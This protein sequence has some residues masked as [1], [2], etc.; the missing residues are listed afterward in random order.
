M[1]AV[2]RA[3]A[4]EHR[5][6][7][8]GALI[9]VVPELVVDRREVVGR[10]LDA[11]LDAQVALEVDVPRARV[12]DDVAI[13]RADEE[14][15]LPER[16][17]QR[18]ESERRVE[19]LARSHHVERRHV[20]L[21]QD[22]GEREA[23]VG[24]RRRHERIHVGPVLRPDVAEQVR[25]N[26]T[27]RRHDLAVLLAQLQPRVRVELH[28]QRPHLI[29]EPI[30]LA[31]ERVGRHVVLR[32]PH[33]P[34]VGEPELFRSLVRELDE[35]LVVLPHRRR[36]GVPPFPCRPQLA[37]V[38]RRRHDPRHVVDRS[39]RFRLGR[40]GTPLALAVH[41]LEPRHDLRQLVR[42]LRIGRRREH[43]RRL[44][45]G[46]FAAFARRHVDV[47]VLRRLLREACAGIVGRLVGARGERFGV[48]GDVGLLHPAGA[49]RLDPELH[50]RL[51][52]GS[53]KRF[54]VGRGRRRRGRAARARGGGAAG[55]D[56]KNE[57]AHG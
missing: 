17:R 4:E 33:R 16:V 53:E 54:R 19:A 51:V 21:L 12:A 2:V 11:H 34:R 7:L 41:R 29:P 31:G 49:A 36:D 52:D 46:Q 25:R 13:A 57:P 48:V 30:E 38:S 37:F 14:R 18:G 32:A 42:L 56:E 28:V 10:L 22:V 55:R 8:V 45:H 27:V 44:Q 47:V 26:R 35:P 23:R 3:V 40:L 1:E 6:I 9:E 50:R 24:V 15:S 39:A 5:Q 43:E 20:A